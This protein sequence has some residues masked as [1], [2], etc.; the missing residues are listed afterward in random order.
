LRQARSRPVAIKM[1][2]FG[3][4]ADHVAERE[5]RWRRSLAEHEI[6][7]KDAVR[8]AVVILSDFELAD[9]VVRALALNALLLREWP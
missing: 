2:T 5:R 6:K 1:S 4:A 7:L 3:R 8:F 9:D